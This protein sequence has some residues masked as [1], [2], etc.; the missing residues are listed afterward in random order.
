MESNTSQEQERPK[1]F[2][3]FPFL[4]YIKGRLVDYVDVET[5]RRYTG[6]VEMY[7]RDTGK[8]RIGWDNGATT[9]HDFEKDSKWIF[10]VVKHEYKG[11]T[12]KVVEREGQK[13]IIV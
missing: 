4:K 2:D 13:G 5:G 10:Q 8:I 6:H 3:R 11:K 1:I 12:F 7:Y 9:F